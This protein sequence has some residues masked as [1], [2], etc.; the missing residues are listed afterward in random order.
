LLDRRAVAAPPGLPWCAAWTAR[1]DAAL[2]ARL[3][4][5][6]RDVA[7][8]VAV[9]AGG[10]YAR[11]Q[12]CPGSDIDLLVVH[13]GWARP[14][15][16]YAV[17]VLCYPLWDAGLVVGHSVATPREAVADARADVTRA[18]VLADHRLVAGD[19]G[20]LDDL[21][22]RFGRWLR[23][24]GGRLLAA[25]G[26]DTA[27]RRRRTGDRVGLL[28]PDLK[29]GTGGLRD[30]H[31]LRWA[32]AC[33]LGSPEP[34]ALVGARYLGADERR[35]LAAA[36]AT[37]L[38][39]RCA[40][41]LALMDGGRPLRGAIDR[42]RL[43]LHADVARRLAVADV[44]DLARGV[45]AALRTIARIHGRAWPALE[46]DLRVGRRRRDRTE[47]IA[48]TLVVVDGQ[49]E[50]AAAGSVVAD[51]DLPLRAAAAAAARSTRLGRL[52]V[53]RLQRELVGD[54]S[55]RPGVGGRAALLAILRA[56]EAAAPV[57]ADLDDAGAL[58]AY[59]PGWTAVRSL[60]QRNPL[61]RFDVDTHGLET[62]IALLDLAAGEH[63]AVWS[64]LA[65]PDM[66]LVA[67]WLHDVGKAWPGDHSEV[68]AARVRAWLA[69]LGFDVRSRDLAAQLVRQHLLLPAAATSRDLDDPAELG[70]VAR[71]VGDSQRLDALFL[72]AL[73]DAR[74]TGPTAAS[75]WREELLATLQRR[76]HAVFDRREAGVAQSGP[77][78]GRL[79]RSSMER[80]R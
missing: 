32:A 24:H 54:V 29:A 64:R 78:D 48:E 63:A 41:H 79:G 35:R 75:G 52:T 2:A 34:D 49:V 58:A 56:G 77:I 3:G 51:P 45:S 23:R 15:L 37:V 44:D 47:I 19:P 39:A 73:A 27:V 69:R 36:T 6:R 18:T 67:A 25:V 20:L 5:L 46:R 70:H 4:R 11:R 14:D 16:E 68:G 53:Q 17:E 12:L 10:G 31:A 61:H 9:V 60:P 40:L 66:L 57:L 80:C 1:V 71:I 21:D 55:L 72:L 22:T 13:D 76:V 62:V 50:T 38:A 42:L 30:V 7:G 65:D 28:E 59:L 33:L 43:D 8:G 74:A 26:R